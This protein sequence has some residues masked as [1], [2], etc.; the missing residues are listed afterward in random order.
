[1]KT[2]CWLVNL[3]SG[4]GEGARLAEMLKSRVEIVPL[5]FSILSEQLRFAAQYDRIV[6]VGGDGT[7]ASLLTAEQLPDVPV[8]LVPI[9]TAND[10]ARE[11]GVLRALRGKSWTEL[12]TIIDGF[13]ER[14]L[15]TWELECDGVCRAF[16][17]Y[18]SLGFEGA[19]VSDFHA[20]RSTSNVQSRLLNRLMYAYFGLR[21]LRGRLRDVVIQQEDGATVACP[22]T[23]GLVFTNIRS[24]M[25]CGISTAQANAADDI[26]EC[27]VASSPLDYLRMI[28]SS[29][30]LLPALESLCRGRALRV[31]EVPKN[32]SVQIDG[33]VHGPVRSGQAV[34]R[35]RKFAK[36]LVPRE[37]DR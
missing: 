29:V 30:G 18:V 9:G 1:M 7:S 31:T 36:V 14:V 21:R 12:P 8:A 34:F 13:V 32:T 15:A 23:R 16:C 28:G 37:F 22:V 25:G 19:V 2:Q 33:E 4:R 35:F 26:L 11:L 6:V 17:N 20:W 10:L 3:R 5:D 24:H 27:V